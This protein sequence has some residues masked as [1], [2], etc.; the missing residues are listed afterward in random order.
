MITIIIIIIIIII[1]IISII[2]II[3]II[4]IRLPLTLHADDFFVFCYSRALIL[5]TWRRFSRG[6]GWLCGEFRCRFSG[7]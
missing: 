2:I 6:F 7:C 4:I 3:I 5:L 1:T